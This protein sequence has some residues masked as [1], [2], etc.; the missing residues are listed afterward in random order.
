[1]AGIES[2]T[3]GIAGTVVLGPGARPWRWPSA[4]RHLAVREG[5]F[6]LGH[7]RGRDLGVLQVEHDQVFQARQALQ[8]LIRRW[9]ADD[10]DDLQVGQ[11]L[12][13]LQPLA[14]DERG[15]LESIARRP[16][17]LPVV[18]I[19]DV[20][21]VQSRESAQLGET[22]VGDSRVD[23]RENPESRYVPQHLEFVVAGPRAEEVDIVQRA[24]V[25]P[26]SQGIREAIHGM[27][28]AVQGPDLADRPTTLVGQ[29]VPGHRQRHDHQCQHR[30]QPA[31][32]PANRVHGP[33]ERAGRGMH[34]REI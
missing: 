10:L 7:A 4:E 20:E 2:G 23:E 15:G 1:M 5:L 8:V 22:F 21:A 27:D 16:D 9:K 24:V 18:D 32:T 26:P 12:Q 11:V 28:H 25:D 30:E 31:S 34:L 29:G 19:P 6:Q 33:L 17:Q 14:G 13:P 3:P